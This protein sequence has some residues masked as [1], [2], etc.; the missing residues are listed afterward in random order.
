ME[1]E[2]KVAFLMALLRPQSTV[3]HAFLG[4]T[5][6]EKYI[7]TAIWPFLSHIPIPDEDEVKCVL[8]NSEMPCS[9]SDAQWSL[10]RHKTVVDAIMSFDD[11]KLREMRKNVMRLFILPARPVPKAHTKSF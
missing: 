7:V 8:E 3:Y 5:L 4:A 11:P 9:H 1:N 2:Q 10:L 6:S